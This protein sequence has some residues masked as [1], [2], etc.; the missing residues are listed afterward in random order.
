MLSCYNRGC[1]QNYDPE[2]NPEGERIFFFFLK[3]KNYH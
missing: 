2:N 3:K 1:G